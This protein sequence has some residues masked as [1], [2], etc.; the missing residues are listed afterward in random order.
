MLFRSGGPF[1]LAEQF[2]RRVTF[3]AAYKTAV[4]EGLRDPFG[5][6]EKAVIETQ[7]LY[8]SG[9]KSNW[10]RNPV[11]AAVLTF[12]QYSVHYLEWLAR[13]YRS[14]PEG[15]KA[16]LWALALLA[17]A[18]GADGLPFAE[19]AEDLADT[20]A[21]ALGLDWSSKKAKRDF[22]AQ[23]MGMGDVGADV[24]LRGLSSVPG[25]PM[26]LSGR[27]GMG[28][29][30]PGSGYFLKSNTNKGND[31]MELAGAAGGLAK[32]YLGG[33]DSALKG[34]GMGVAKA[35]LPVAFQ[36]L[37]KGAEMMGT[38]VYT[39]TRGRKVMD[40]D[41]VDGLMKMAGFQPSELASE[42]RALGMEL[43][44]TSLVRVTESE[45]ADAWAKGVAD[46]D[47]A[48]VLKARQKLAE[49]NKANP[50]SRIQINTPQIVKRVRELKASREDRAI[51]AAP[52]GMRQEMKEALA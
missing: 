45:I 2:N 46:G 38:G 10:A 26:D 6:A 8:N 37:L 24:L 7:G 27:M 22:I 15:K 20:I 21:Q 41:A 33:V 49:W 43:R 51:K 4:A 30:I 29:L 34:D 3:L 16:A 48:A 32:Q 18:G 47:Q 28:N 12:K 50:D 13:M 36:N 39:D 19:D 44:R 40:V 31:V 1:A 9:N 17:L 5:F 25:V 11:G 14:G 23:T 52:K 35:I 42:S